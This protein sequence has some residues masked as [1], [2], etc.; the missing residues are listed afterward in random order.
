MIADFQTLTLPHL[1]DLIHSQ[2]GGGAEG[3]NPPPLT[4]LPLIESKQ[5]LLL[6]I[7][8][9]QNLASKGTITRCDLSSRCNREINRKC[10]FPPDF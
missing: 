5:N 9:K 2:L 1:G 10:K 3:D 7:E 8:S 4:L 6:L